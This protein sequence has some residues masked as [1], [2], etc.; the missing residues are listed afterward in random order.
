MS[1]GDIIKMEMEK[2]PAFQRRDN[3]SIWGTVVSD[4]TVVCKYCP[5]KWGVQSKLGKV[6]SPV[7][8]KLR[9]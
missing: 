8:L 2:E 1:L 4:S 7:N 5:L 3:A 9:R 6:C